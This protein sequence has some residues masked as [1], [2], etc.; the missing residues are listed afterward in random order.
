MKKIFTILLS[1]VICVASYA[2]SCENI[3]SFC[4]VSKHISDSEVGIIFV[5]ELME[6][7]SI[8]EF[9]TAYKL[10]ILDKI[11]GEVILPNSPHYV[12][13]GYDNTE[14]ELWVLG[15]VS[16][17]CLRTIADGRTVIACNYSSQFGY[18]P[19]R[20]ESN[21]LEVDDNNMVSG[22]ISNQ[23][24]QDTIHLDDLRNVIAEP[25]T[26]SSEEL[27]D[28][29][30]SE[31]LIAPNPFDEVLD[32]HANLSIERDIKYELMDLNGR[33]IA[34]ANLENGNQLIQ[35]TSI[36]SGVYLVRFTDG[37]D[38]VVRKVIKM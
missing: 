7:D 28:L 16:S 14:E 20:C 25:C 37:E 38:S 9:E 3:P 11:Y 23:F 1:N 5:G 10:R 35:T 12:D 30:D 24:S 6:V 2:C 19:G 21:Y 34:Q 15:G 32:I 17:L 36:R 27:E 26:T 29:I 18:V 33:L 4:E 22:W 31:I 13:K 8:D